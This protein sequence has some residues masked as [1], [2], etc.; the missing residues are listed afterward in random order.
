MSL[1]NACAQQIPIMVLLTRISPRWIV[2]SLELGWGILTL[3]TYC[4]KDYKSLYAIRFLVGLF[5]SGFYVRP[6]LIIFVGSGASS[7]DALPS[8]LDSLPSTTSSAPGCVLPRL[9][10][11]ARPQTDAR[12]PSPSLQYTPRE[13]AKR[14]SI[15]YV[16][17]S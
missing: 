5:E 10:P 6:L 4:V 7:A 13:L 9:A 2:P 14:T 16:S 1:V 3:A 12:P 15:F 8:P 17:G 11:S